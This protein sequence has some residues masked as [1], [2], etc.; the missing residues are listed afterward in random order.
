MTSNALGGGSSAVAASTHA[1]CARFRGT[2]PLVVGRTRRRTAIDIGFADDSGGIPQARWTRAMIFEHLV[3]DPRFASE[4]ATTAVGRLSLARPAAVVTA[5]A[6]VRLGRTAELL[7]AAHDRAVA[8]GEATLIH[9]LALPFAGFESIDST[10]VKPD[11]AIVA[12][13]L[14]GA[15]S[16]LIVGDAK[17]YERVRSRIE[18]ARLLK[19]FLQV[20]VGAES[21]A[22][23][24]LLPA[25]MTVHSHGVLAVPRNAFLR[26]EPLLERL[27]DYRAEVRMRIAERRLEAAAQPPE[28]IGDLAAFVAHLHATFD[29]ATCT[30]CSLFTY[31]RNEI[32]SSTDPADLLVELG[33][34]EAARTSPPSSVAA[35]VEAT[36]TGIAQETGQLRIDQADQPG[37]INVVLAKSDAAALG[38][39]GISLQRGSR[40]WQRTVFG[41]PQSAQ[42][43]TTV[44]RILGRALAEA[45][46][47]SP[48]STAAAPAGVDPVHLVVPDAATADVLAAIADNLA[49]IEL[50]RLRWARDEEMGREPLTFGGEPA[51]V[52]PPLDREARVAVS[53]LLEEDRA[54]ALTLRAPI[55]NIRAALARHV[56]AGG[57]AVAAQRLDYLVGWAESVGTAGSSPEI[58]LDPRAF[59]DVIEASPHTPGARLSNRQSDA[60]H[61]ARSEIAADPAPYEDLVTAELDYKSGVLDRARTAL[62][63]VPDSALRQVFRAL[64]GDAQAVW[65]RRVAL[66]AS[67]LVRFGRTY[68]HWRNALVPVIEADGKCQ[69]QLQALANPQYAHDR[70]ADAGVRELAH[71][72]VVDTNP[73]TLEVASRRLGDGA[74]VVLIHHNGDACVEGPQVEVKAQATSFRLGGLAIGPLSA[75]SDDTS[76]DGDR[77]RHLVWEPTTVPDLAVG[78]RLVIADFAWFS[79]NKGN[80][81]L[82]VARPKPD[83]MS[84]PKADCTIESYELDPEAHQY[85]CRPHEDAEADWSDQL[86]ERR[87]RGELNP[88]AWPPL[89]DGDAFETAPVNIPAAA[90]IPADPPPEHLTID[91]L[92]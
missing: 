36:L 2:D 58:P 63:T 16:W 38:I 8:S 1:A 70:A 4:I 22:Q 39:H 41:D 52:P 46:S 61:H 74:R 35:N 49:G 81:H 88:Q 19:G 10:E 27:D 50:S 72:T 77:P 26:P 86:A 56:V 24:S 48:G 79:T 83:A 89:I 66:H 80:A 18:D 40:P 13:T 37:A 57:P 84:A 53:F 14:S 73:I 9:G 92:E 75:S 12:P 21:A 59:E 7:G 23:W 65:R 30:T 20:A 60:I 90:A 5:D 45:M 17:D 62:A 54:R 51:R 44:M 69:S 47:Q 87:D 91:D 43:R 3:Q 28:A 29:P 31:C 85:C 67:D 6:G 33:I 15:G 78:D 34:P 25:G 68:R 76:P 55:I 71:A 64:E 11:F 32:R 42:T 82:N